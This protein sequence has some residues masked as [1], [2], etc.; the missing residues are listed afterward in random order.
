MTKKYKNILYILII[1]SFIFKEKIFNFL[2]SKEYYLL[3]IEK[4]YQTRNTTLEEKE[5]ELLNAYGYVDAVSYTLEPS[6]IIL[7]NIYNLNNE[8]TIYKGSLDNIK[9]N[10][11]VINEFGLVGVIIKTNNH[12]SIVKLLLDDNINI[13][14]KINNSYGILKSINK[15]LWIEGINNQE[16]IKKGDIVKTSDLSNFP[17]NIN[18]GEVEEVITDYYNIEKKIKVKPFVDFEN[19]KYISIITN[20]RDDL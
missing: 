10:M 2:Y 16:S 12:S 18:I 15:E 19:L 9:E 4:I 1:S 6:K 3:T 8:I 17:E 5:Q 20:L 7:N 11:L 13:S 14:I